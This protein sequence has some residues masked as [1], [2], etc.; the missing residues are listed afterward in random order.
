MPYPRVW[1]PHGPHP[2]NRYET[3]ERKSL[4]VER[5]TRGYEGTDPS[6]YKN[7]RYALKAKRN[8]SPS[9]AIGIFGLGAHITEDD[10]RDLL[11]ERISEILNYRVVIV[12][13]KYK[14]MSK[15]YGFVQ[16]D[17]VDDAITARNRLVGQTI[18]GKEIRVDYSIE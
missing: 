9:R 5:P 8:G 7:E 11:K 4:E 13:D 14:R 1:V 3:G 2:G 18:K 17:S 6:S 16:F 12:Y 10:V 15:G